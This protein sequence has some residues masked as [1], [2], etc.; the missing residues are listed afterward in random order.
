VNEYTIKNIKG[1]F[2]SGSLSLLV[3]PKSSGID[4]LMHYLSSTFI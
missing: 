3:G 1:N 2:H 4:D